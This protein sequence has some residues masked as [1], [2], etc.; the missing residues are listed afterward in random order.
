MTDGHWLYIIVALLVVSFGI[1]RLKNDLW[2]KWLLLTLAHVPVLLALMISVLEAFDGCNIFVG[3]EQC[4]G[5]GMAIGMALYL[6]PF[7]LG[8]IGLGFF[9]NF[10]FNRFSSP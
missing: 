7:W 10:L 8:A 5:T 2:R 6:L 1:C 9:A 3:G 4:A